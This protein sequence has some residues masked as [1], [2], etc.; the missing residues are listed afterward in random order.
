MSLVSDPLQTIFALVAQL[1]L[2][3]VALHGLSSGGRDWEGGALISDHAD[4]K[5][6]LMAA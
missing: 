1:L 2:S 3:F 6:L 5:Y 4:S